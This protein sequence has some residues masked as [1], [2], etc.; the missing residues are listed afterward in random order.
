VQSGAVVAAGSAI[1]QTFL[2][3]LTSTSTGIVALAT[4]APSGGLDFSATGANL[5]NVSLGA[6]GGSWTYGGTITPY[7]ANYRLGGGGGVLTVNSL[8]SGPNAVTATGSG[9]TVVLGNPS[10]SFTGGITIGS[11]ATLSFSTDGASTGDNTPLGA[12][13][14]LP[15]SN[16]V[17]N[18]GTLQSTGATVML[19]SNRG[20]ALPTAIDASSFSAII[21]P[22]NIAKID[23]PAGAQLTIPGAIS[24]GGNLQKTGPGTLILSGA[25]TFS[26]GT[27]VAG[28]TLTVASGGTLGSYLVGFP[29]LTVNAS[30]NVNSVVNLAGDTVINALSGNISGTGTATV[31]IPAN[32]TLTI[33]QNYVASSSYSGEISGAGG[34]LISGSGSFQNLLGP[35]TYTGPTTITGG[36]FDVVN[37]PLASTILVLGSGFFY[38]SS[39]QTFSSTTL[40]QGGSSVEMGGSLGSITR[41]TNLGGITA[42][43]TVDISAV[44]P[45]GLTTTTSNTAGTILGG[46]ATIGNNWAVSAGNGTTAGAISSLLQYTA[47]TWAPSNNTQVTGSSSPAAGSTTNSLAFNTTGNFTVTL[48]GDNT[49]NSGGILVSTGQSNTTSTIT[50]GTLT[51]GNGTDLIVNQQSAV[52]SNSPLVINSVITGSIGLTKAG[53]GQLI[54]GGANTYTGSTYIGQG[55]VTIN[56]ESLAGGSLGIPPTAATASYSVG[57]II[58]NGDA[59]Q[60][61]GGGTLQ[62]AASIVLNPNRTIY[63]GSV[64]GY[65]VGNIDVTAGNTLTFGGVITN[66]AAPTTTGVGTLV[67]LDSGTLNITGTNNSY[68]GGTIVYGG[69]LI[70]GAD[71]TST[72]PGTAAPLGALPAPGLGTNNITLGGGTLEANST[73]TINSL[74]GIGLGWRIGFPG[75]SVGTIDVTAGNTL[76]YDG[77]IIENAIV[78]FAAGALLKTDAGT[79]V[80]GGNNVYSGGTTISGGTLRTT[81]TGTIGYTTGPLMVS[82]AA[83]IT[84]LLDLG[85]SQTVGHFS[86]TVAPGGS[87]TVDIEAATTFT[88]NQSAQTTFAGTITNSGTLAMTS[89]G[90]GRLELT[91]AP[92]LNDNSALAVSG[93]TLR[94]NVG[95]GSSAIGTGVIAT[96]SSAG[97]LELAG[98]VSALSSGTNRVKIDNNSSAT[99]GVLVSGMHQVVGP[100]EGSGSTQVNAG[101]DLTA[102]HIIQNALVI[103]GTSGSLALVT[104]DPSDASGNPMAN[105]VAQ[106]GPFSIEGNNT[107]LVGGVARDDSADLSSSPADSN[108]HNGHTAVPEPAS[109]FLVV[110]GGLLLLGVLN[111]RVLPAQS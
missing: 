40:A 38:D 18:N 103:G 20:I 100:I 4:D 95:A 2:N 86:G 76:T 53:N 90:G 25:N 6:F 84:S 51:S 72:T 36:Q 67:K 81:A 110:I 35:S 106:D 29:N 28:G 87:A 96:V 22:S 66:N 79:L 31:K 56:S 9:S 63:L 89:S 70:A 57:S 109:L 55:T 94:F 61:N 77:V 88:V 37:H 24:G 52:N 83:G 107:D 91:G 17:I 10:N 42:G 45:T 85:N 47:N 78:S 15:T 64:A 98:S 34:L 7:S 68:S 58:V 62:A 41:A 99:A 1:D 102:D 93:G 82:A 26:G 101:S 60:N 49:I 104:I 3:S 43:S 33:T 44:F 75:N 80:L 13:P 50:G 11:G 32:S 71:T 73:Y 30:N 16:I 54:L 21:N 111:R 108:Q 8:L 97:T 69:V 59:A 23:V 46:W 105:V 39:T 5:P 92:I 27:T 74:R 48:S 19:N 14:N 12:I 65:G